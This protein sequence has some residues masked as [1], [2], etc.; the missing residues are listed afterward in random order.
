MGQNGLQEITIREVFEDGEKVSSNPVKSVSLKEA[1]PQIKMIGVQKP[2]APIN[3]PGRLAYLVDGDA[4]VMEGTTGIRRQVV[5]TGDLDGRIFSL[6]PDGEW[7]LFTRVSEEEGIINTLWA[8]AV[9][10]G[11]ENLVDLKVANV[12]HIAD[13]RP[14]SPMTVAYS[15]V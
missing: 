9:D 4:W 6:S 15:T 12:V 10:E 11:V 7:L 3:I 13:R 14:G 8:A 5:G 2:F 1:V